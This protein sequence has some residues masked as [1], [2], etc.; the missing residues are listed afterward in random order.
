MANPKWNGSPGESQPKSILNDITKIQLKIDQL[1][2][3]FIQPIERFR[4][5]TSPNVTGDLIQDLSV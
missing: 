5:Y 3:Q 1:V 2:A 4:S